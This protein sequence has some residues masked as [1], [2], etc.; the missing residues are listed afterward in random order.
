ME[1]K[2]FIIDLMPF[3]YNG[4]FVFLRNPR[5]TALDLEGQVNMMN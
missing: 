3:P 2:L 4:H 5:L 1:N